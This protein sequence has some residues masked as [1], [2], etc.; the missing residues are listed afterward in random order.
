MAEKK[1]KKLDNKM[2]SD[3]EEIDFIN[4]L[5]N[6]EEEEIDDYNEEKM[7]LF[8][9][10]INYA[11]QLMR[12]SDSLT[13][14]KRRILY[15]MYLLGN[16]PGRKTKS[17]M[18]V[19]KCMELHPHG[20]SSIYSTLVNMTQYWKNP[21]PY[22]KGKGSFGSEVMDTYAHQRYTEAELSDYAWNCFFKDY[23]EECVQTILNT[24]VGNPEPVSLPSRY[25]N[26]L[27]NGGTGIAVGNMYRIPPYNIGEL[28]KECKK[29]LF[30]PDNGPVYLVP[31]FPTG[32]D[33]ID[34]DGSLKEI[35]NK[36]EGTLRMRAKTEI[37]DTKRTW[38]IKVTNLPWTV[39]LTSVK[40]SIIKLAKSGDLPIK[41]V[42]D[43]YEQI[44]LPNG[45]TRS[46]V[47]LRIVI[48]QS[49]DPQAFVEKLYKKTDL[50][51]SI[52]INFK[53]VLAELKVKQLGLKDLMLKWIDER[54]EYKRRLLNKRVTKVMARIELLEILIKLFT[55]SNL[56][57]TVSI[58]RKSTRAQTI[59]FLM[60]DFGM[61]SYQA[62]KIADMKLG[63]FTKDSL[64]TF[65]NE[66]A[67]RK[68]EL[69]DLYKCIKSEKY[70]DEIISAELD[71]LK[72]Y[73]TP[74][75]SQLI[76]LETG[77]IDTKNDY[78]VIVTKK[79]C[80]KKILA[81]DSAYV[82]SKGYGNFA[83]M[84]YPVHVLKLK[85]PDILFFV[86]SFGRYSCIPV[87]AIE[88]MELSN[89]GEKIFKY[90]KLEGEIVSMNYYPSNQDNAY[91]HETLGTEISVVTV[92]RDG[93]IKK[94]PLTVI[95]EQT[96]DG[97]KTVRNAKLAKTKSDD[98]IAYTGFILDD[99]NIL[100]YT[101]KGV[102]AYINCQDV[103]VC[104]KEAVGNLALNIE[105]GDSC[106]GCCVVN[107][108]LEYLV[109]VTEKGCMKKCEI[110]YLGQPTKRKS[111]SYL[112]TLDNNDN[113]IYCDTPT[114]GIFVCT[115]L[116]YQEIKLDDIRTLS[117]KAKPVKKIPLHGDMIINVITN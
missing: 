79:G 3:I 102:Y 63:V 22:I 35:C 54:R 27:I 4:A 49:H 5:Y 1:P 47:D 76:S 108:E 84:D 89:T 36:G 31:D 6:V 62:A 16:K 19:G 25:P 82:N 109:V 44:I 92:S 23:D 116:T 114:D 28:V 78:F 112:A 69:D 41:D 86:D 70:I 50:D 48:D 45:E 30:K 73:A 60:K 42:Y 66:L 93:Y 18:I 2:W 105:P 56:E 96:K 81:N 85:N 99:A 10:N 39:S 26:A 17:A 75:K 64:P 83:N 104:G 88:T 87:S 71:E 29:A 33:I 20:D 40:A 24:T 53:V 103:P 115:R 107:P 100:V 9:A 72:K 38:T 52:A 101:K 58:I 61:T 43:A 46:P 77:V 12:L 98:F 51:K 65:K 59:D 106:V 34:N 21:V 117:R 55:G 91:I 14:V 111:T 32:C 37:I 13:P 113:I 97:T 11:R 80:I 8:S 110:E 15:T 74:R 7:I 67:E 94:T 57:K 68:E 90:T 95:S